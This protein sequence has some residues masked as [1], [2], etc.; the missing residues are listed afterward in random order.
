MATHVF[1]V[2]GDREPAI[3][4]VSYGRRG[5]GRPARFTPEQIAQ[6]TRTVRRVPE[7]MVKVSGGGKTTDAVA[8]HFQYIDRHG[9][10][11]IETDDGERLQG[12]DV[13]AKRPG[14]TRST[15]SN[16]WRHASELLPRISLSLKAPEVGRRGR[17]VTAAWRSSVLVCEMIVSR[18]EKYTQVG[19]DTGNARAKCLAIMASID[20]LQPDGTSW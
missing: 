4:I 11:E 14:I 19:F 20:S 3:D 13:A 18:S 17:T 1:R 10:L 15:I 12:K 2:G 9:E 16:S 5:P 6:I 8:A 7:V